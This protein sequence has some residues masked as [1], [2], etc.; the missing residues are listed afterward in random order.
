LTVFAGVA[1]GL[2]L[3]F[4]SLL[5]T[6]RGSL[7]RGDGTIALDGLSS[8]VTVVRD[9]SG[10]VAI[11]GASREDVAFAS[12]FVHA[13][14]R[15]FQMDLLRRRSSGELAALFGPAAL[16]AD[17]EVRRHRFRALANEIETSLSAP[18]RLLLGAYTDGV[19]AGLEQ[20]PIRPFEYL[21]LRARPEPWERHDTILVVFS[22]YLELQDESGARERML[23]AMSESMHPALFRAL[24]AGGTGWDAPL[25]GDA[26]ETP[27]LPGPE[28]LDLRTGLAEQTARSA[29]GGAVSF[30]L[31][32]G[33]NAW[34][35]GGSRTS[36]GAA[37][38]ANDMHLPLALP[39]TWYRM[40]LEWSD[41]SGRRRRVAGVSLPGTPLVAAGSNGS[42]A[43]GFTNSYGD[44]SDVVLVDRDS[45]DPGRYLTP[46]GPESFVRFDESIEVAGRD[47]AHIERVVWTRWGPLIGVDHAGREIA[48]RWIAHSPRAVNL[49]LSELETAEK[50]LDAI[51]IAARTGIPAQNLV[52][53]DSSGN[54]GW[55]V[56]GPIPRRVGCDEP[57]LP[58]EG[59]SDRCVWDGL[60]DPADYPVVVNPPSD[61]IW[62][63]NNRVVGKPEVD[64]IGDGGY[65][66]GARAR[67]I[68]DSLLALEQADEAA[69]L[70]L[71]LDNRA[72]FLARWQ[73][74]LL[75]TADGEWVGT[76]PLR[77][78]FR[79]H[80][81]AWG[82][83]ASVDSVG[84]RI[85]R[86]F[87]SEV[88]RSALEPLFV[89]C[90]GLF[91]RCDPRRLPQVE[92]A[93]W[94]L[95]EERP[96]HLLDPRY[97][98]WRRLLEASAERS[99]ERL[100]GARGTLSEATWGRRNRV[101]VRHPLSRSL[102]WASRW[103]DAPELELP[104]DAWMP[105]VQ[106]PSFGASERMVVS[107][108]REGD[109]LFHA[110]GGQGGH[111]LSEHYLVGHEAWARGEAR[112]LLLEI[113]A[114]VLELVP[115]GG[116]TGGR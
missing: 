105:R 83:R 84:Y 43:W 1:V 15:W 45:V 87:R 108:G 22:M 79:D 56:L 28:A 47:E 31:A 63:A 85:V 116:A 14:E 59:R 67:Q 103:I 76:D 109:G 96:A 77:E 52:V 101:R 73:A 8:P 93:L 7:P 81:E 107:P 69:L 95:I 42:L 3:L 114:S 29:A 5:L 86:S 104:G 106:S 75:E 88:L 78:E 53:G 6:L 49:V 94:S 80:V 24:T 62:T 55:T 51:A 111:P 48:L 10:V 97:E 33:S 39:N 41:E 91:E 89:S 100:A 64:L 71:Q 38:V 110:P 34:A 102:G 2:T 57:L 113:P 54:I 50:A 112:P 99:L 27:V 82:A 66:L 92:G 68:R 4:G 90:R 98:S 44:W 18:E 115:G 32:A 72:L 19:N 25:E 40:V 60:L 30:P 17:R 23:G 9:R 61:V 20:L 58:R 35:V 21:L 12:G 46:D 70:E 11:R 37:I 74:L 16:D 13:Q 36:H 26:V 65:A